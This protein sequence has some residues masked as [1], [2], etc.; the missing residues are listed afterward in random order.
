MRLV[1]VET[2]VTTDSGPLENSEGE[3]RKAYDVKFG[4]GEAG[5]SADRVV[6]S[7]PNVR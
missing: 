1:M 2:L 5:G 6:V 7:K 4:R 3:A